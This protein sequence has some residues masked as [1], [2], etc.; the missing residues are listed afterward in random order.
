I[1]VMLD[2]GRLSYRSC[3]KIAD[4]L[5]FPGRYSPYTSRNTPQISPTVQRARTAARI[6]GIRLADCAAAWRK[7]SSAVLAATLSR[8]ARS[9]WTVAQASA[10]ISGRNG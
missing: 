3:V 5:Q 9:A 10:S 2:A 8:F 6:A 7:A 4:K 1:Q